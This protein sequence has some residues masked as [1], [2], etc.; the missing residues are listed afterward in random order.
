MIR[1]P[2][3]TRDYAGDDYRR[4]KFLKD[5]ATSIF[6]K[7]Q[8]EPVVTPV[9]ERRDMLTSKYGEEE[10]LIF[11]IEGDNGSDSIEKVNEGDPDKELVSLRYD[12]TVPFV[13]YVLANGIDKMRRYSVG[14]VFRRETTSKKRKRLR[15]FNQADFDFVGVFDE[16]LPEIQIFKMINIFFKNIGVNNYTINYN[17]RDL[18]MYYITAAGIESEMFK[19][20]CTSMDKIN[21]FGREY[22]T[23]ELVSKGIDKSKIDELF[24]LIDDAKFPEGEDVSI[25]NSNLMA[26]TEDYEITNLKFDPTLAR[27]LDYYTG[28]IFEVTIEGFESSVGGGGRYDKLINSYNPK[29]DLPMIGFSLGLDRLL[30]Y[31]TLGPELKPTVIVFT[32]IQGTSEQDRRD[33]NRVKSRVINMLMDRDYTVDFRFNDKRARKQLTK[34][35]SNPNYMYAIIIGAREMRSGEVSVKNLALMRQVTVKMDSLMDTIDNFPDD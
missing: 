34:I 27:G 25:L 35:A 23:T 19:D 8:G 18:L 10:R 3:G 21:K 12:L 1:L 2:K 11:N 5:T 32:I 29:V 6:K 14:T 30:P 26:L 20:V 22:V 13:R 15:A 33:L 7:F 4:M 31:V 24:R 9:F 17:Y 16:N 28:I